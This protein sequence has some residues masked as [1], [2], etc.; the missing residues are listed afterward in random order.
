MSKSIFFSERVFALISIVFELLSW[1]NRK[2]D[3]VAIVLIL[4]G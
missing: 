4:W 1:W 2:A 3:L